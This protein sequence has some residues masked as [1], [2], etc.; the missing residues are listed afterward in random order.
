MQQQVDMQ[1]KQPKKASKAITIPTVKGTLESGG[2][3]VGWL[4]TTDVGTAEQKSMWNISALGAVLSGRL[5]WAY[6]FRHNH[7]TPF[8]Y[9]CPTHSATNAPPSLATHKVGLDLWV[10]VMMC[11]LVL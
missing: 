1:Q 9:K 4:V 11:Q 10:C 5:T 7:P 3:L 8:S 6:S 2:P